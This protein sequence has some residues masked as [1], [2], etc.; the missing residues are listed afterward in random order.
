METQITES[1][2]Q[3]AAGVAE[4]HRSMKP[5]MVVEQSTGARDST[6]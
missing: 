4:L 3:P 2:Y 1:E 6:V 5:Q